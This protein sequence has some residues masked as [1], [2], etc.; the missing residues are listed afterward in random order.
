MNQLGFRSLS[1]PGIQALG[2][3]RSGRPNRLHTPRFPDTLDMHHQHTLDPFHNPTGRHMVLSRIARS[4]A[5]TAAQIR[6]RMV[7]TDTDGKQVVL[8]QCSLR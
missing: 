6:N 8:L 4:E 3:P 2:M 5:S 7:N 1:K